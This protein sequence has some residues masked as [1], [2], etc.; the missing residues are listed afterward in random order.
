MFKIILTLSV[1]YMS[2]YILHI[3]HNLTL[4]HNNL[5]FY[6]WNFIKFT[7]RKYKGHLFWKKKHIP[8]LLFLLRTISDHHGGGEGGGPI[9]LFV[10]RFISRKL[11]V[12]NRSGKMFQNCV[13]PSLL[14]KGIG[15]AMKKRS[16]RTTRHRHTLIPIIYGWLVTQYRYFYQKWLR[17]KVWPVNSVDT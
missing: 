2:L 17:W 13:K 7:S 6:Y 8:L 11:S 14:R 3:C 12:P 4:I 15:R 1:I 10:G 9:F 5:L 16:T